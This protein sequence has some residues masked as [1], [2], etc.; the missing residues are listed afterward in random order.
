MYKLIACDLD[1]TLLDDDTHVNEKN[2][3]AIK[4]ATKLGVK[5]VPATGRGF[6][7]I[8]NTL[9]EI[10]LY[11]Q[12]HE[13]V[14][15]YNG[16]C[17]S[18]NKNNRVMKFQGVDFSTAEKLY[19]LGQN[20][21]VCIHVYT[22]DMLYVYNSNDDENNYLNNRHKYKIIE[23]KKLNFLKGQE[24]AKVLYGNQNM[25]YLKQIATSLG[26]FTTNLDVSYSSN[27][28]L[29]FNYKGVNK[30]NGLLWL[31]KKLNI[32]PEETIAIGDNFNDL[33]M[34]RAA[35]LGVG[36]ANT[37]EEMKDKCDVITLA[38][39]NQGGVAEAIEKFVLSK[40]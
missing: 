13:Y 35:G 17:I 16:G 19:E 39:N 18:E 32:K 26:D 36:V 9:K 24:I 40:K 14:I 34:I 29:E 3:K 10:N 37:N 11:D 2:K 28:Y 15:S 33:S 4:K 27:R 23:N 1:E 38:D 30:G 12:A 22:K 8:Q 7:A 25:A 20:Y 5:F 6:N 31:A 21:D